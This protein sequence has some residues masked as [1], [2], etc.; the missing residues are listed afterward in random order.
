MRL[1]R[2]FASGINTMRD[3]TT[4]I[5]SH[6]MNNQQ[7]SL[8]FD[9]NYRLIETVEQSLKKCDD[10]EA[11][12]ALHSIKGSALIIDAS[13]LAQAVQNIVDAIE[14]GH[15]G[16]VQKNMATLRMALDVFKPTPTG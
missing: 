11:L 7:S 16:D 3:K 6:A 10:V 1:A 2:F 15:R 12:K 14:A 5:S 4:R 9:T 13:A 8:F